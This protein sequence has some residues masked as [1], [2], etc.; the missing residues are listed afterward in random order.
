MLISRQTFAQRFALGTRTEWATVLLVATIP[1]IGIWFVGYLWPSMMEAEKERVRALPPAAR[2]A[3]FVGQVLSCF[4]FGLLA[5]FGFRVM[6]GALL[7]IFL[8]VVALCFASFL[9]YRRLAST[10][11]AAKSR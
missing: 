9:T 2:R 11:K 3:S 7:L 5:T 10:A 8:V 6:H 1:W 4:G